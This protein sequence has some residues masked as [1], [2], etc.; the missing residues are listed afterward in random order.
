[1]GK[2]GSLIELHSHENI[3]V[4]NKLSESEDGKLLYDDESILEVSSEENNIIETK[5]DGLY[6]KIPDE[7]VQDSHN[8]ENKTVLDDISDSEGKLYYKGESIVAD[9]QDIL[10]AGDN[11]EFESKDNLNYI[12]ARQIIKYYW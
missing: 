1:M 9:K 4:L 3:D 12:H 6:A 2:T 10:T 8:H 7:I 11:I 5:E